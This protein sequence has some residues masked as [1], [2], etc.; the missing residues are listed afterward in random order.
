MS[1]K[2]KRE[3]IPHQELHEFLTL[4][5]SSEL[6]K[7]KE[8]HYDFETASSLYLSLNSRRF[9]TP[10]QR[11]KYVTQ[12]DRLYIN[13]TGKLNYDLKGLH[14]CVNSKTKSFVYLHTTYLK[15]GIENKL[16]FEYSYEFGICN[17]FQC[18]LPFDRVREV[19]IN[20]ETKMIDTFDDIFCE[21]CKVVLY[22]PMSSVYGMIFSKP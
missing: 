1:K 15:D 18:E 2:S 11:D 13:T 7:P 4:V 17:Y 19:L 16:S 12:M 5:F 20:R 6:N 10:D 21:H 8:Y 22:V 3:L 9:E 14:V